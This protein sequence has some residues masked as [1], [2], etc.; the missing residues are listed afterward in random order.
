[1]TIVERLDLCSAG[2]DVYDSS[3]H[4]HPRSFHVEHLDLR[5][6]PDVAFDTVDR[7]F[8]HRWR[9]RYGDETEL[10]DSNVVKVA[11]LGHRNPVSGLVSLEH[12]PN[13][14]SLV[15]ERT[16]LADPQADVESEHVHSQT[17]RC[18]SYEIERSISR[19][20]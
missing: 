1:M 4:L 14:R 7:V 18:R 11:D 3:V 19:S 8:G 20:S 13:D 2:A 9:P 15:F 5:S 16:R 17:E 12:R 6:T 10:S